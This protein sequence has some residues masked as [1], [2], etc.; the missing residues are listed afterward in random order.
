MFRA[1][2][3]SGE[4]IEAPLSHWTWSKFFRLVKWR[5]NLENERALIY[6]APQNKKEIFLR[7]TGEPFNVQED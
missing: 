4:I 3:E 1:Y 2:F 5:A 6:F 7:K